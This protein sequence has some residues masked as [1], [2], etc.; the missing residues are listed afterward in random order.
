MLP[1]VHGPMC[2]LTTALG[3]TLCLAQICAADTLLSEREA[4]LRALRDNPRLA[5]ARESVAAYESAE[6]QARRR[7]NPELSFEI[8]EAMF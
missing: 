4:V 2:P 7:P 3:I 5:A 6:F 8:E 1:R